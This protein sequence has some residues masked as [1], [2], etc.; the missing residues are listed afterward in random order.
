MSRHEWITGVSRVGQAVAIKCLQHVKSGGENYFTK[1]SRPGRAPS[2]DIDLATLR[3]KLVFDS[4]VV[5]VAEIESRLQ[6]ENPGRHRLYKDFYSATE[7]PGITYI[8]NGG[9]VYN[10]ARPF[11]EDTGYGPV[12]IGNLW[13]RPKLKELIG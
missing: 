9:V 13:E 11:G 6:N 3:S 8:S 1:N 2:H 5:T 10:T 4:P 7:P 12:K